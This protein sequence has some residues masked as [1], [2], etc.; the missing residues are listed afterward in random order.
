MA[1]TKISI[2]IDAGVTAL[3]RQQAA[4]AGSSVSAWMEGAARQRLRADAA[5][6]WA[7]HLAG[8]DAAETAETMSAAYA[9]RAEAAIRDEIGA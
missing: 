5:A 9:V 4:A 6:A 7:E 8:D 3:V 2:S 1:D